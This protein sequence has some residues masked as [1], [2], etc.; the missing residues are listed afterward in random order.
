MIYPWLLTRC[1]TP[2][3]TSLSLTSLPLPPC[4]QKAFR[5]SRGCRRVRQWREANFPIILC[6]PH[7][8]SHTQRLDTSTPHNLPSVSGYL[9]WR[10]IFLPCRARPRLPALLSHLPLRM[11]SI[12]QRRAGEAGEGRWRAS[13][14]GERAEKCQRSEALEVLNNCPVILFKILLTFN[15]RLS[16]IFLK[17][18]IFMCET[19]FFLCYRQRRGK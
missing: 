17:L 18:Y 11:S 7:I 5:T 14:S 1:K 8:A 13:T 19:N 3:L 15:F 2:S 16:L 9:P 6:S 12:I 4:Q 10:M